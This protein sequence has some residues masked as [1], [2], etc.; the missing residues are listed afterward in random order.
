VARP[1]RAVF[2]AE[3]RAEARLFFA[4][5]L[6]AIWLGT[7]LDTGSISV[8]GFG[9]KAVLAILLL[10]VEKVDMLSLWRFRI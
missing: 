1:V 3:P 7:L 9:F 8:L 5:I 10:F 6:E 4:E 2:L